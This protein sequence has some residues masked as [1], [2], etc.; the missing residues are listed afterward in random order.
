MGR[1]RREKEK[2]RKLELAAPILLLIIRLLETAIKL[3]E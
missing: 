1:K 2:H 3:M